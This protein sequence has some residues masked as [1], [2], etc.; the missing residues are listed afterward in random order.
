MEEWRA[1]RKDISMQNIQCF[2]SGP[3]LSPRKSVQ[4]GTENRQSYSGR[5]R[6]PGVDY[7]LNLVCLKNLIYQGLVR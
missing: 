7:D 5:L 3:V 1:G 4:E 6:D 2:N